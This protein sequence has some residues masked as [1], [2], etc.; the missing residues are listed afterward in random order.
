VSGGRLVHIR[1]R[2]SLTFESVHDMR[3]E[4]MRAASDGQ[5]MKM[6]RMMGALEPRRS[7]SGSRR[8]AQRILVHS[9][10]CLSPRDLWLA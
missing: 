10:P 6:G 7:R 8:V 9:A 5:R 1:S 2:A 4:A 3:H